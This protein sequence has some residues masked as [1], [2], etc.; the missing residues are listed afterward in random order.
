MKKVTIIVPV[1]NEEKYIV[2]CINSVL[3]FEIPT[4]VQ[5]EILIVDG[6]STDRTVA[7]I[8]EIYARFNNIKVIDNPARYQANGLNKAI[9]L[10]A[11]DY[12]M[13]LDAHAIYPT[14][15]LALCFEASEKNGVEN[16][17]GIVITLKGGDGFEAGLVQAMTTHNF[18]VGDS[19]FRTK[20]TAG[21]VDT[22][23]FGFFKKTIFDKIGYLDERLVRCQDYEFNRRIR[24][25]GGKLWLDSKIRIQYFNQPTLSKFYTKQF[26]KEA[27]YNPYMWFLAPYSF[28]VRH[29][30]TSVFSSGIL[31]GA[32]GSFFFEPIKYLFLGVLTLYFLLAVLSSIQQAIRYKQPL[33]VVCLPFCFFLYHFIHGLGIITGILRLATGTSPV[34]KL[35]EP[36]VGAGKF[37]SYP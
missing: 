13:R 19:A 23:P 37:R 25:S 15:Y 30:I 6:Q 7:I 3:D 18:G 22:V 33:Y 29:A 34:Q 26:F 1:Y 12:I 4:G 14:N 28:A 31:F 5:I 24:A 27:P 2:N 10:A 17:G 20:E 35:K 11:G 32:L 9:Q 21:F 16:S 8:H 36:W